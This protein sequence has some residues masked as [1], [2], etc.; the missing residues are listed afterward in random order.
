MSKIEFAVRRS[1]RLEKWL[2]AQH[3]AEGRGLHELV[4]SVESQLDPADVRDLRF[5]AA[6]RN[7]VVHENEDELTDQKR[8][9]IEQIVKRVTAGLSG[10]T[11]LQMLK[12]A[13]SIAVVAAALT[14]ATWWYA[15][16]Q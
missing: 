10:P 12:H 14:A 11:P 3:G 8:D 9:R 1:Q 13:A 4:D 15:Q 16:Q 7:A 6:V 2:K 5:V